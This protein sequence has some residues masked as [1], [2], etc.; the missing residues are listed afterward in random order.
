[1]GLKAGDNH[2]LHGTL[3]EVKNLEARRTFSNAKELRSPLSFP[4]PFPV[5]PRHYRFFLHHDHAFFSYLP[6]LTPNSNKA[7]ARKNTCLELR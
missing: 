2:S 6:S 5:F 1:M 7:F 3:F 4:L